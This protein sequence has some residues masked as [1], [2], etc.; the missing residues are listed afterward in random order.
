[1]RVRVTAS[2]GGGDTVVDSAPT[3]AVA[4]LAPAP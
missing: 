2:N 4:E 1:M 3:A